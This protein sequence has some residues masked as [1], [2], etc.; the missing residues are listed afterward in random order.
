MAART[1]NKLNQLEH[2][3]PEGLVTDAAWLGKHGYS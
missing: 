1:E 3:L 2:L